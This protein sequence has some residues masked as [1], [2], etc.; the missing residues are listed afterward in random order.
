MN[1]SNPF[2]IPSCLQRA[3]VQQRRRE[4][5]RRSVVVVVV[6]FAALLLLLLIEGCVSERARSSAAPSATVV[7]AKPKPLPVLPPHPATPPPRASSPPEIIYVVQS[8]DT[9]T[10]IARRHRTSVKILKDINRLDSDSV[11]VGAKLKLPA[12]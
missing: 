4:R 9:L 3:D 10:Q 7:V 8:G 1:A 5:F 6:A 11:T 2:Q 12:A